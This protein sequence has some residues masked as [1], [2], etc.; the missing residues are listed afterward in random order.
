MSNRL[1]QLD[2]SSE[3]CLKFSKS[4]LEAFL[5]SEDDD[6]EKLSRA[7]LELLF[8]SDNVYDVETRY[9]QPFNISLVCNF[10][11]NCNL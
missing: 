6:Q 5:L 4:E 11:I 8:L 3:K 9:V 2:S 1:E 10:T 7:R